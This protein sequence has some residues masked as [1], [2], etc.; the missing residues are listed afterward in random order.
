MYI[1]DVI[2]RVQS[3]NPSEYSAYELYTWCNEVAAMLAVED[4]IVY[5]EA[6][7]PVAPDHTVLLPEDVRAEN[8]VHVY[9]GG[10]ELS[11]KA[12]RL[13]GGRIHCYRPVP[14]SVT[15]VYEE[16]YRPIR[17][18]RYKGGLTIDTANDELYIN[19]C[20]FVPGDTLTLT[21]DGSTTDGIPVLAIGYDPDNERGYI[22][23]VAENALEG[24]TDGDYDRAE[25][26][27]AVTDKTICAAPYDGMYI[28]YLLA[29]IAQYQRDDGAYETYMTS[30]NMKLQQYRGWLNA[31]LPHEP[32]SFKNF[33]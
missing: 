21:V 13:Q 12:Y 10:H 33:W 31:R 3:Y 5:K 4:R 28:D 27:R 23:N 8:I 2:R 9:A 19:D 14:D 7:L 30:F 25:V 15:V 18:I 20:E 17:L 6:L 24:L 11:V 32:K 16:P 1:N 26:A 29:K 22:L